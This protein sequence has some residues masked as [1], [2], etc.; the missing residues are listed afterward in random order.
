M[1]VRVSAFF[2]Y[3]LFK[4]ESGFEYHIHFHKQFNYKLAIYIVDNSKEFKIKHY[5]KNHIIISLSCFCNKLIRMK[6][7]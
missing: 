6:T 7:F 4:K 5:Q 3:F 1:Y 2:I